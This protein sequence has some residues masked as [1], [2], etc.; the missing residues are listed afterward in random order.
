[1]TEPSEYS[2][3][4]KKEGTGTPLCVDLDGTLIRSDIL[5]ESAFALIKANPVF[6]L[7]LPVWLL[8]GKSNLKQQIASRV[9]IAVNLLPYN[10]PFLAFL[11]SEYKSGRRLILVTATNE[12]YARQIADHLGIFSE[13]LA[14]DDSNNLAGTN[15]LKELLQHYGKK[16]FDY[17]ANAKVDLKIWPHSRYAILVNPEHGVQKQVEKQV[18]IIKQFTDTSTPISAMIKALRPHQWFKN[19]LVFLPLFASHQLQSPNLF[20]NALL[21]FFA[22]SLCASSVYLLND[23]L[24]LP[25][26]RLHPRKKNRP[27]ASGQASLL[28]GAALIPGLLISAFLMSLLLPFQ[29]FLVL[30]VYYAITLGYSLRFKSIVLFDVLVLAGLYTMRVIAGGAAT[31]VTPSFWLLAFSMSI[32]LSLAL[33]KRYTELLVM[34]DTGQEKNHARGYQTG[35]LNVLMSLGTASGYM[36][37]VVLA[38]Y[39]NSIDIRKLYAYPEL[40]WL[41]CPLLLYWIS[42]LWLGASR[43]KIHDDPLVFALRDRVSQYVVLIS[44]AITILAAY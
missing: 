19:I 37:I 21:A 36:A 13:V 3:D 30:A 5:V 22:F 8:G 7:F 34:Q 10:Q 25:S 29:F 43:N 38:F 16:G 12:K 31:E 4:G 24:D 17:A 18:P 20:L 42:R 6:L 9:D 1:M 11:Q 32:F 27:F 15:K 23:L 35:D 33:V 39:I 14:S 44:A 40:F 2:N 28:Y 26:D 41:L